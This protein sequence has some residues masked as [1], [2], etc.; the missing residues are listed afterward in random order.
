MDNNAVSY[1]N[2]TPE[3][4]NTFLDQI[5]IQVERMISDNKEKNKEIALRDAKIEELKKI[6]SSTAKMREKLE[7]YEKMESSLNNAIVMAQQTSEQIRAS[8]QR[9]GEMI[10]ND[11]KKNANRIVN[12]S[13]LRA[14]KTEM[15]ADMLKRNI[16][17][18]KRKLRSLIEA[19]LEMVDDIE[20]VDF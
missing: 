19:Q 1:R 10:V 18:F 20:K 6:I 2:Y 3:Q 5:I 4:I 15:E 16:K 17:I 14:E 9:E 11:A 8:A 7:Q 13:L 12:E